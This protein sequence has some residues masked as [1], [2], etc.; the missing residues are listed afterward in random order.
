[1]TAAA[2]SLTGASPTSEG[3][4][5]I[6]WKIIET[7]VNRLQMRIAKA[8]RWQS[9]ITAMDTDALISCQA[10]GREASCTKPRGQNSQG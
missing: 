10:N 6:N 9:Q 7:E 4:D 5:S 3:W 8:I 1:M 2:K